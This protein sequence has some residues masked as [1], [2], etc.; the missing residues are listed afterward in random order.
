MEARFALVDA[1]FD[2]IESR[3]NEIEARFIKI[4]EKLEKMM[5]IIHRSAVKMEEQA[6]RNN[7]VLDHLNAL[8]SRQDQFESQTNEKLKNIETAIKGT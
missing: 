4:D 7:I 3:L 2:K 5:E 6:T 8:F 1:R